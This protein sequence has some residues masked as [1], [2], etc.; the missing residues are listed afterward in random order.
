MQ[1]RAQPLRAALRIA[2]CACLFTASLA[3]VWVPSPSRAAACISCPCSNLL[4]RETRLFIIAQHEATKA[5]ITAQFELHRTEFMEKFFFGQNLLAALRGMTEQLVAT[6]ML[7]IEAIGA[8]LDAKEQLDTQQLLQVMA[9]RA[10]KNYQPDMEMCTLG[11]ASRSLGP[12]YRNGQL[13]AHV[14]SKRMQD[15]EFAS[16]AGGRGA[17]KV[18]RFNQM[19]TTYCDA[20]DHF[21]DMAGACAPG[22]PADSINR[23]VDFRETVGQPLTIDATLTDGASNGDDPHIFALASNLYANDTVYPFQ[24]QPYRNP[25]AHP[26]YLNIREIAARRNV[27]EYSFNSLVGLKVAGGQQGETVGNFAGEVYRQLGFSEA[28][29]RKMVGRSPSYNAA[30]ELMNKTVYLRPEFYINLYA[31]PANITRIGATIRAANLM[32]GMDTFNSQLRSEM[33]L[34]QILEFEVSRV[35]DLIQNRIGPQQAQGALNR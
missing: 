8:M 25:S 15:R 26:A 17:D 29:A 23:D 28:D 33:N 18:A 4:W 24:Q 2:I 7:Q 34:S 16:G 9:A 35:H 6:G 31:K 27:A 5:F 22:V 13:A 11:S 14:L 21:N 20:Q 10:H 32:Q 1:K 30:M 12:A 3:P 19:R